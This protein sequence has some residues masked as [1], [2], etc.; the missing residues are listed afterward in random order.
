MWSFSMAFNPYLMMINTSGSLLGIIWGAMPGLSST[1]GMA[2]LVGLTFSMPSDVAICFMLGVFTGTVFGG[3]ITATL[4]NIPGT[5]DN[6]P[7]QMAGFPLAKKGFGGLVLGTAITASMIG[8]WM[9]IFLLI[10]AVPVA[11]EFALKF[12]SWELGLLMLWGVAISGTLTAGERPLKGW[13]SGWVGLLFAMVGRELI[14]GYERF[15]FG[16]V[17][18]SAGLPMIPAMIGLFG[19]AEVFDTLS[20]PSP[21][22]LPQKVGR[23]FPPLSMIFK[24]WKSIIRS[25]IVGLLTGIIP[26]PGAASA[27]YV[28]YGLGER[29]TKKDFSKGSFEGVICCEVADNANIGGQLLPTLVLGIPGSTTSA[30]FLAALGLHGI[31]LG[32]TIQ[33]EQPGILYFIF[34]ALIVAN[35]AMYLGAFA[36][37]KPSVKF[38]ALPKT[39]LLPMVTLLCVIGSFVEGIEMFD[40][41]MMFGFGLLGYL[42]RKTGFPPGPMILGI[43]LGSQA[44]QNLRRAMLVFQG[45]IIEN[46]LSRP[47]GLVLLAIVI[48]T[49]ISG[50]IRKRVIM[51][52][53]N[54]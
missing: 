44:D 26:G 54:E 27:T 2:L 52:A 11:L 39:L 14:H 53:P 38:F 24:Y 15:T 48:F 42:M 30:A 32:P 29:F 41:Y 51:S 5:P 49:F 10:L 23:V 43:I 20:E 13:I 1:M 40:V 9:G 22:I 3:A 36:L 17:Y 25:S 50:L 21:Y 46:I 35:F 7:E 47:I 8:N 31:I 6:V 34:G 19:L 16:N 4:I 12:T 28:S 37:I 45:D 33:L 18:L